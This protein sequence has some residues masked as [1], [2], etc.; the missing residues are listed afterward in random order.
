MVQAGDPIFASD[1]AVQ[2]CRV[3]RTASLSVVDGTGL[4]IVPF[5]SEEFDTDNMHDTVTNNS[6]ITF[7]T[8]GF[9]MVGFNGSFVAFNAY[10][11]VFARLFLNNAIEIARDQRP[12]TSLTFT[13]VMHATTGYYFDAGD[14]LE[15]QV[16]QSSG[17]SRNLEAAADYTPE[18]WA[19][20]IGS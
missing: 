6:R 3:T 8:A 17:A 14:Y 13:G 5:T 9:Y 4:T 20:R 1:V 16:S 12:G 7:N 11:R 10:T 15:V 2:G 19:M 18:F